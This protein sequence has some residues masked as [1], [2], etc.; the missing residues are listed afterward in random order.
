MDPAEIG[1]QADSEVG[2]TAGSEA[3]ATNPLDELVCSP[4]RFAALMY[5]APAPWELA[6]D[7]NVRAPLRQVVDV[8]PVQRQ[9]REVVR[10]NLFT[11]NVVSPLA[12][13]ARV[14]SAPG[15]FGAGTYQWYRAD[16]ADGLE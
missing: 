15:G 14:V 8:A 3:C 13:I 1:R 7:K 2:D 11:P 16:P 6:A 9:S 5:W 12:A 4:K 10:H